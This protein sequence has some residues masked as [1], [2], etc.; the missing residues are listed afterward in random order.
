M[1]ETASESTWLSEIEVMMNERD[2]QQ[3]LLDDFDATVL[4]ALQAL[5]NEEQFSVQCCIDQ[6]SVNRF[7]DTLTGK[8]WLL[9]RLHGINF[10]GAQRAQMLNT[11]SELR[12]LLSTMAAIV[13]KE[14]V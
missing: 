2:S 1:D 5:T 11:I 7:L 14:C 13:R 10:K 4:R 12:K 6:R 3:W 8:F 9:Q